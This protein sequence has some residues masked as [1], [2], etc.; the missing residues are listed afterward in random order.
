M[1]TIRKCECCNNTTNC[2]LMTFS[3]I[4]WSA[5]KFNQRDC[6]AKCY[7]PDHQKEFKASTP[8]LICRKTPTSE[9]Q[10]K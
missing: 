5:W 10:S 4:G 9:V 6:K 3:Q 2:T 1:A 8:F 7:C